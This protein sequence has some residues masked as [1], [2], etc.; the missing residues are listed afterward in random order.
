M[1]KYSQTILTNMCMVYD[2]K[3]DF[4]VQ[5][6]LKKDWPGVNF[7]GGHVERNESIVESV[8]RELKEETGLSVKELEPMGYFEWNVPSGNIRHVSLLFRTKIFSGSLTASPEGPVFWIKE[9]DLTSYPQSVDFD[10]IY[11]L[12]KKNL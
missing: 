10:K 2:G 8:V 1:G 3:G 7:P 4:L 5:N 9:S 12:M 11:A 6:R